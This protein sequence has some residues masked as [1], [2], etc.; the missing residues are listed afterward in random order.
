MEKHKDNDRIKDETCAV[1]K[2]ISLKKIYPC[3]DLNLAAAIPVE[4][5]CQ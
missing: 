5:S 2:G 3:W 1:A 4:H